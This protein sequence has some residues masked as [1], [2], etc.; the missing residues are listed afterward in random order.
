[1][2]L[3][4]QNRDVRFSRD[5]SPYKTRTYGLVHGSSE[6]EAGFYA[7]VSSAGLFAGTGYHQFAADQLDR[8]RA[9]VLDDRAGAALDDA[10]ADLEGT[11]FEVYGEEL[12]TAP[13]GY[14]RDHARARLL[15]HK[16]VFGGRG[17]PPGRA[18]IARDLALEHVGETWRA[19]RALNDWLDA[20]VGPSAVPPEERFRRGGR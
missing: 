18:G 10:V 13:R 14:P 1:V 4:R 11:G 6:S 7:Q 5:K 8:F 17:L 12:K 15:R 3:F 20:N 9:A 2:K 19:G 16:A